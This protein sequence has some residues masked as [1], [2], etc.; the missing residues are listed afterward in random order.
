[1]RDAFRAA[2]RANSTLYLFVA[3]KTQ[4]TKPLLQQ[5]QSSGARVYQYVDKRWTDVTE[6]LL[7]KL[8]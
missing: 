8:K 3:E 7:E 1:M 6:K 4:F 5:I 2:E